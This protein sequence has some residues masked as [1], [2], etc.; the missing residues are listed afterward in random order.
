MATDLAVEEADIREEDVLKEKDAFEE[1]KKPAAKSL[2]ETFNQLIETVN[3]EHTVCPLG[4]KIPEFNELVYQNRWR[5]ALDRLLETNNFPEFTGRV[6]P[7][8]CEAEYVTLEMM[9]SETFIGGLIRRCGSNISRIR[10][11]SGATIKVALEKQRVD[12]YIYTQMMQET[13]GQQSMVDES[14]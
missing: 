12:E 5:E 4:N 14:E 10:T 7:A 1:L 9:I 2:T 8:P 13:G 3:L 11:E 6:C